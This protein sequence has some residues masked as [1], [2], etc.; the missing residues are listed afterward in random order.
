M[1]GVVRVIMIL[2][3][4]K[5]NNMPKKFIQ[6]TDKDYT[7][8]DTRVYICGEGWQDAKPDLYRPGIIEAIQHKLGKHWS[9][10][11]PFCVIC[12]KEENSHA[13]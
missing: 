2:Q 3:D 1:A 11:Q 4:W 7:S 10:G 12:G 6:I 9:Y 8:S 13:N 5:K